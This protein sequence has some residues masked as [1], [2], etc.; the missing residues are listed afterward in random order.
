MA[1]LKQKQSQLGNPDC[2]VTISTAVTAMAGVAQNTYSNEQGY[3]HH[4]L[5]KS[6]SIQCPLWRPEQENP[7]QNVV[8]QRPHDQLLPLK[9]ELSLQHYTASALDNEHPDLAG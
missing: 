9:F 8:Q 4:C 7:S 1:Q 3:L 2:E 5:Q 6:W